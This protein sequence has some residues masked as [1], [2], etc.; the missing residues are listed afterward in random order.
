MIFAFCPL[1]G[2]SGHEAGYALLAQLYRQKTGGSLPPI[3]HTD[4]GKPY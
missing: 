3:R 1:E 4:R 2:R